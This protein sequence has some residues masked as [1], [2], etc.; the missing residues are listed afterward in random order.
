[1]W[2]G[3]KAGSSNANDV[4]ETIP[5]SNNPVITKP[6]HFDNDSI[7]TDI[8]TNDETE[9]ISDSNNSVITKL[10]LDDNDSIITDTTNTTTTSGLI[11]SDY[12]DD[13]DAGGALF[14][15]KSP[16][17]ARITIDDFQGMEM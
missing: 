2:F 12:D 11:I 13:D 9:T 17:K 16:K 7:V 8:T 5:V 14:I 6:T 15:N 1:M 10:T 3:P 4:H